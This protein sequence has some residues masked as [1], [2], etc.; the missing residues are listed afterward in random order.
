MADKKSPI[1]PFDSTFGE[2][3]Q[4]YGVTKYVRNLALCGD[5]CVRKESGNVVKYFRCD[6]TEAVPIGGDRTR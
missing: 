1:L 2:N 5:D 4:I 6:T 3:F